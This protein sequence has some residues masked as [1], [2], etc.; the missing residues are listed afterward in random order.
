M[1]SGRKLFQVRLECVEIVSVDYLS[2]LDDAERSF[3]GRL[4]PATGVCRSDGRCDAVVLTGIPYGAGRENAERFAV[5]IPC[6]C[7]LLVS[8]DNGVLHNTTN[9]LISG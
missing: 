6:A 2:V 4:N 7:I 5:I 1:Y 8:P 3:A 9:C